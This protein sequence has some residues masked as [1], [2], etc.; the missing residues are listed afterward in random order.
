[1]NNDKAKK[2]IFITTAIDYVN[3]KPHIGHALEKVQADTLARWHRDILHQDVYFLTGS[4]ENSLK[5]VQAAKKAGRDVEEFV[6]ENVK[7]FQNLKEILNLSY[8][9]FIRT[10]EK[11]HFLGA[12]KLW[13]LFKP[14]DIYKKNYRGLYCVGCE[15]FKMEKDLVDGKCPEHNE[16]PEI[17]SEE[18]YFFKLSSYQD[19]LIDLIESDK[20]KI[21]PDYRKNEMLAFIK[22]GLEDFSISRSKNR[23]QGWG[24][25][26][27]EAPEQIM[28]VWVDA[29]SNYITALDF[30]D[31][32]ELY[33]KYWAGSDERIHVIGKGILRFHAVYWPAMLLSAGLPLPTKIL[34]HEYLTVNGQKISKTIGNVIDPEDI[35]KKYGIDGA[36]YVLLA[37]MP[38]T[39]DGDI[40][41]EKMDEKY[42]A[43]LANNLGNLVSRTI[44]MINKYN[45]EIAKKL[46]Y[47]A[48]WEEGTE[49]DS[50]LSAKL[51]L[52]QYMPQL[53]FERALAEI[54]RAV[55]ECNIFIDQKK[56]WELFKNKEDV[57]LT[58]VLNVVYGQIRKIAQVLNPFMPETSEKI[59][60]QLESLEPESLFPRIEK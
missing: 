28:Y 17:V 56:P 47:Y 60:G 30:A 57:E 4:D 31:D 6:E 55:R 11:K 45:I 20:L 12:Q 58:R 39:K 53:R 41:W 5:N 19:K 24:V 36:R 52:D 29:L 27:P 13:S 26:V 48:A 3:A 51:I 49:A 54:G 18:N 33:K 38:F 25:P 14:E 22:G 2:T 37:S 8:D 42:N 10:T 16:A 1:M 43:D 46:D 59:K 9:Q 21:E 23:A 50:F 32:G 15:E 44:A 35:V 34:C 40:S 7:T